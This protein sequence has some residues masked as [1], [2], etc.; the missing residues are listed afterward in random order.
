VPLRLRL[1]EHRVTTLREVL[2][3]KRRSPPTNSLVRTTNS[4][5]TE[6]VGIAPRADAEIL[7]EAGDVRRRTGRLRPFN[8][9][10]RIP[11][12]FGVGEGEPVRERL[13]RGGNRR[14]NAAIHRIVVAQCRYELRARGLYERARASGQTRRE[15]MRILKRHISNVIYRTMLSDARRQPCLT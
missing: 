5:L 4:T 6:L 15:A 11:A 13:S 1:I 7:V 9:T 3:A 12:T 14:L 2:R 8:G 10:A